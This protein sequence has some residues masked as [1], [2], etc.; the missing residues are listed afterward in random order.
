MF[1]SKYGAHRDVFAGV[2][3]PLPAPLATSMCLFK[4]K[5]AGTMLNYSGMQFCH[6]IVVGTFRCRQYNKRRY[7]D[8][9]GKGLCEQITI[10]EY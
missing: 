8:M 1:W 3:N 4:R 9:I 10:F 2:R 5:E 7:G 6:G